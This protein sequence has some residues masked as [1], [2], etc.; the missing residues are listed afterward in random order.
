MK[1]VDCKLPKWFKIVLIASAF[2][3]GIFAIV[4]LYCVIMWIIA[5]TI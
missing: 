5:N 2:G 4:G 1:K 3:A